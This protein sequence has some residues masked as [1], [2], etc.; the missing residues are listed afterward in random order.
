M[1]EQNCV[2]QALHELKQV[3][4][5]RLCNVDPGAVTR[6]KKLG[7]LPRTELTGETKYAEVIAK[8]SKRKWTVRQLHEQTRKSLN[9]KK[10]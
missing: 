1:T 9:E 8:L 7:R 6:W 10:L 5:A 2:T 3:E 4:V